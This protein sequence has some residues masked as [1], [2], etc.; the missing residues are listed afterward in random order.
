MLFCTKK[1]LRTYDETFGRTIELIL[2][3]KVHHP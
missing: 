2:L 3:N 1:G